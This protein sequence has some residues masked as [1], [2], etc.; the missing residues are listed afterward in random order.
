MQKQL[1]FMIARHRVAVDFEDDDELSQI[2]S[3][4]SLTQHFHSLAK[5][6]DTVEPK[7][8]ED[9][10]KSHLEEKKTSAV[11]DS[12]KQNLAATF[13]NAGYCND[14]L[15][16]VDGSAWLYKNKEHGMLSA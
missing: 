3:N 15:M 2:A 12:A 11:L 5:S 8:P 9:I 16:L 7:V 1:A 14:K 10:Y 6:L 13:V 4:S